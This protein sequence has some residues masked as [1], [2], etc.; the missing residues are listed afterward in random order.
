MQN[1]K[2]REEEREK[3]VSGATQSQHLE[4]GAGG[5]RVVWDEPQMAVLL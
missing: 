3:K 2:E 4:T 5:G 1:R